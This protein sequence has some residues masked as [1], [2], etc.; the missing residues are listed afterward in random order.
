MLLQTPLPLTMNPFAVTMSTVT[1]TPFL[2]LWESWINSISFGVQ[3]LINLFPGRNNM[4]LYL[5]RHAIAVDEGSPDY[6][7]ESERPLTDKGRKKMRQMARGLRNLGV[8]FDCILSSPY[9]RARETA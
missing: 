8:E 2:P 1:L 6:E 3:P 4:N 9:A 5:V 7:Q